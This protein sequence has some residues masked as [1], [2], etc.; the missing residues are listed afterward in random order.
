M[1]EVIQAAWETCKL[2]NGTGVHMVLFL[3]AVLLLGGLCKSNKE[4]SHAFLLSGYTVCFF[5]IFFCPLT[6]K[7]IMDYCIGTEVYWR[8]FWI[9][10]LPIVIA[11]AFSLRLRTAEN[12]WRRCLCAAGMLL[13]IAVTGTAVYQPEV[14][15]EAENPYKLPQEVIDV[16]DMINEDARENSIEEK[17]AVVVNELLPYIRQYDGSIKM[18]Y[19]RDATRGLR[20]KGKATKRLY[21]L[22]NDPEADFKSLAKYAKKKKCNYLVYYKNGFA[23]ET[24]RSRGYERI[25]E[26]SSYFV[27]RLEE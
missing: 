6:A 8:M 27:Y 2:F 3:A 1:K 14:F 4:K 17:K 26:T 13:V 20:G 19:G 25:G 22:M 16:C 5:L 23:D 11:Y 12:R 24:L 18:P 15:V 21:A 9:L 7:V 10:P